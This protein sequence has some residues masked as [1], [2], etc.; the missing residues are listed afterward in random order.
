MIKL[1]VK[2]KKSKALDEFGTRLRNF[3]GKRGRCKDCEKQDRD[4]YLA[5]PRGEAARLASSKKWYA[6]NRTYTLKRQ[7]I[8]ASEHY[9]HL[10]N[11]R[12]RTLLKKLYGMTMDQ[13]AEM[14]ESQNHQCKICGT[15]APGRGY[16]HFFIDHCHKTGKVR[17]LLCTHCN[18]AIG[19]L[20]DDVDRIRR[21]A[22]YIEHDGD[23][24]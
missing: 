23:I 4:I 12:R 16:R 17:G 5:T 18:L 6:K 3:D 11:Y 1:C 9:Q 21:A 20:A 10:F 15:K 2:C 24:P 14:E 13:Y 19:Q 7:R 22:D 8:W